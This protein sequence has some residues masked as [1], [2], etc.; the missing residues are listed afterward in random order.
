MDGLGGRRGSGSGSGSGRGCRR[1]GGGGGVR[2]LR[3]VFG[4]GSIHD[5]GVV[6]AVGDGLTGANGVWNS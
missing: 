3:R 4:D 2:A 1:C 6:N 5:C